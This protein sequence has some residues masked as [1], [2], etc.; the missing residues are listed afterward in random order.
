M[1]KTYF[2]VFETMANAQIYGNVTIS[3]SKESSRNFLLLLLL[4]VFFQM[5]LI[6]AVLLQLPQLALNQT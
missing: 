3:L 4:S 1:R 2:I 5:A 6:E